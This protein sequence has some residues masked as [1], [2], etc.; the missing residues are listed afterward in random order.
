MIK[1]LEYLDGISG[2]LELHIYGQFRPA[3]LEEEL[4]I[5]QG[6][7]YVKFHGWVQ[8]DKVFEGISKA[9]IGLLLFHPVSNHIEALPNKL[10]EYMMVGLPFVASDFPLWRKLVQNEECGLL[11][12]PLD[13]VDI[14]EKIQLLIDNKELALRMGSNGQKAV[15]EKYN[16]NCEARTLLSIYKQ[17]LED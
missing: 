11:A 4:R 17:L 9:D 2:I 16:W 1:A 7:K 13:P 3:Q 10:F 15:E 6:F 5:L 12:N 14:S 8:Q